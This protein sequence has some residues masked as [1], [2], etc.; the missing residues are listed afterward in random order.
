IPMERCKYL[1][2][3]GG[4][5]ADAAMRGIREVDRSGS[6]LAVSDEE[7]PTYDR[8]PL[9]KALWKGTAID[10]I[11]RHTELPGAELRLNTKIVSLDR[12]SKTAIDAAG[13]AFAYDRLLLATG[14]SP[15]RICDADSSVIYFRRLADFKRAWDLASRG[16][17]FA[18]IG[19]GFIGS[20]L[21]AALA[22]NG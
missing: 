10:S 13:N 3:G 11:W 14:G 8:P 4:L 7:D 12:I 20:E 9:S 22:M 15:R 19:G 17:Q 6:I 5:A 16:A 1:I 2:I 21:A 18:V